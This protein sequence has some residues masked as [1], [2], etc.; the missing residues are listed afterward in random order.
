MLQG[1]LLSLSAAAIYGFLG[2]AFELAAKRDCPNW[3]YMFYKQLCGTLLGLGVTVGLRLP[4]AQPKVAVMATLGAVSYLATLWAYLTASRE[5]D[6]AANWTIVNLSVAVPVLVSVFWFHDRFS[7]SKGIGITFTLAAIALIG[8]FGLGR[9]QIT[10]RWM[11]WITIAFLL[12]GWIVILLRFVPEG[13]AAVF[14]FYFYGISMALAAMYK[15]V[16]R[17]QWTR[18]GGIFSIAALGAATHWSGIML[19]ILA[20]QV[21]A[22]VSRQAGLVVY[23]ITN[24]LT[25]VTGA[26]VGILILR[27]RVTART[28]WGIACGSVAMVFLSWG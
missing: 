7:L 19:T 8:G 13:L 18:G 23:P 6:I 28:A 12:N 26:L 2:L 17:Q 24:G 15:L 11:R 21:V 4:F 25:I 20:L 16:L 10:L 1:I 22:R 14:T 5:R 9:V 27:Q 3:D